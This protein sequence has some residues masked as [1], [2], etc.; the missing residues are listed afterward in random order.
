MTF[1][2]ACRPSDRHPHRS[3]KKRASRH[4]HP[5]PNPASPR[6]PSPLTTPLLILVIPTNAAPQVVQPTQSHG[7]ARAVHGR[8]GQENPRRARGVRQQVG[9]DLEEH[10]WKVRTRHT[11]APTLIATRQIRHFEVERRQVGR[12]TIPFVADARTVIFRVKGT[13][14]CGCR[15]DGIFSKPIL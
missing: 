12:F 5:P 4:H 9:R 7:E 3:A 11:A 2:R 13:P 1:T 10:P 8:R 14:F 15:C 6:V